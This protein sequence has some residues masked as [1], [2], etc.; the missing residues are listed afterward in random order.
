MKKTGKKFLMLM[1][2]FVM[3]FV[4][5]APAF[6]AEGEITVTAPSKIIVA[7]DSETVLRVPFTAELDGSTTGFVKTAKDADGN[8]LSVNDVWFDDSYMYFTNAIN[9]LKKESKVI[10]V[11]CTKEGKTSKQDITV[12]PY[13]EHDF[14]SYASGTSLSTINPETSSYAWLNSNVASSDDV[15]TASSNNNVNYLNPYP[16]A[17]ARL[18]FVNG[19]VLENTNGDVAVEIEL[20]K[21]NDQEYS[22]FVGLRAKDYNSTVNFFSY[23]EQADGTFSLYDTSGGTTILKENVEVGDKISVKLVINYNTK[24]YSIYVDGSDIA[25]VSNADLSTNFAQCINFTAPITKFAVYSGEKVTPL[26]Y[27]IDEEFTAW[28]DGVK[29]YK[30]SNASKPSHVNNIIVDTGN[31]NTS[32]F[33][34]ATKDAKDVLES[35]FAAA[36]TT[37]TTQNIRYSGSGIGSKFLVEYK[38]FIENNG[39]RVGVAGAST[40]LNYYPE[41]F[42]F[43]NDGYF[44]SGLLTGDSY[45]G[46]YRLNEWNTVQMAADTTTG[47]YSIYLNGYP[48]VT[49]AVNEKLKDYVFDTIRH[50]VFMRSQNGNA[51]KSYL[52][53]LKVANIGEGL[54]IDNYRTDFTFDGMLV[55][56]QDVLIGTNEI[57]V[58][59]LI[60]AITATGKTVRVT[61]SEGTGVTEGNLADGYKIYVT[62]ANG[63]NTCCYAVSDDT[64]KLYF[65]KADTTTSEG[66]PSHDVTLTINKLPESD[67]APYVIVAEYNNDK[68]LVKVSKGNQITDGKITV[69]CVPQGAT[70]S[71]KAF[72]WESLDTLVPLTSEIT[73]K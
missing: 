69:N 43:E 23:A 28:T 22:D 49:E 8:K 13:I 36:E 18:C 58:E 70:T 61:N 12:Y 24:K 39:I 67:F 37:T 51:H 16:R 7:K 3:L 62:S 17:V 63:K 41:I 42:Y 65:G 4:S 53:Y 1:L 34:K 68:Q 72:A 40:R 45:L 64:Y 66:T 32:Y 15:K 10:T 44:R 57:N 73:V 29:Y 27:V 14:S 38:I 59:Q 47:K 60:N 30:D 9:S 6:A 48:M 31:E 71:I 54:N 5:A 25:T 19:A 35:S 33:T 20:F 52:D 2:A 46:S 11:T 26:D 56:N 50:N 21:H 55:L